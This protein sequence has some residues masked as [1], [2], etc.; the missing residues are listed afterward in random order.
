MII[1]TPSH[2]TMSGLKEW[3]ANKLYRMHWQM[4]LFLRLVGPTLSVCQRVSAFLRA[5][6][7]RCLWLYFY[8]ERSAG[9]WPRAVQIKVEHEFC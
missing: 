3:A 1:Q 4:L 6:V 2:P 8:P 5:V 7:A 9:F